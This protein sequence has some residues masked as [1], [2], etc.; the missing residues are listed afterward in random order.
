MATV[1]LTN[2]EKR[3]YD[4]V[5]VK[6]NG[7]AIGVNSRGEPEDAYPESNIEEILIEDDVYTDS[8]L[9]EEQT[10]GYTREA[11]PDEP[12]DMVTEQETVSRIEIEYHFE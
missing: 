10:M 6:E 12:G 4:R 2:G 5:V 3:S 1:Y 7:W 8:H 9:H 11:R